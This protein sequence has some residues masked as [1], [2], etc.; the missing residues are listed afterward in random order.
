MRQIN[1]DTICENGGECIPNNRDIISNQQF[2]CV[3][4]NGYSGDR[5]EIANNELLLLFHKD[6]VLSQEIFIHFIQAIENATHI[7]ST[8]FQTIPVTVD[9][10]NITWSQP[11]H[12]VFVELSNKTYYLTVIQNIYIPSK[13]INKMIEPSDHCPNIS[14]LFNETFVRWNLRRRI[15]YYHLPCQNQSLNLSCFYDDVHFCYCYQFGQ[16]RLANCFNFDH[17]MK[18]NCEGQSECEHDGK[19]FQ[20][21]PECPTKSICMCPSCFFGQRCQL[22][23]NGFGLSLDV[24]LGYQILPYVNINHQL[25]IIKI[26]LALT[27]IFIITGL[28]NGILSLLTFMN[29]TVRQ[30]GCGL[31]LLCSSI[32]TLFITIMFGLKFFI[33]LFSHM[34]IISNRSFLSGQ[35]YSFDFILRIFLS[36]DQ[37]LNAFIA[38]ERTIT[39]IKGASFDKG[40][41]KTTAKIVIAILFIIIAVSYIHDPI[42]R[43][44]I[45]E[46]NPGD[47]RQ[48]R[49]WCIVSYSSSLEIYNSFIHTFHFI[50]PF[51]INLVSAIILIVKKARQQSNLHEQQPY[52]EILY[53]TIKEHKNLLTAAIVLVILGLP[54]II[55]IFISKCMKSA[56]DAWLFLI[57]YFISFIPPMLI[58]L[59]YILPSTFYKETLR[60]TFKQYTTST[61]R[62]IGFIQ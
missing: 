27:I 58:S 5:C 34:S 1:N 11:F 4:P 30:V 33:L 12:V 38:I 48:N 20:D 56:G 24:I 23:T 47:N 46:I 22:T 35:C 39:V 49:I 50:G 8:T 55:L 14:E 29:K 36:I 2:T 42:H 53:K 52:K 26:S 31:Y 17:N 62:W 43:K 59:I 6:I 40:K 25:F 41:S 3:S 21:H 45:D 60:M 28:I 16:K 15:K 7:R 54:R 37:W 32:T 51:I 13:K 44:S 10:I 18:F 61:L 9:L 57:G 19:C